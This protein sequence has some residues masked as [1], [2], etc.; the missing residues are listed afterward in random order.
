MTVSPERPGAVE[1]VRSRLADPRVRWWLVFWTAVGFVE[2]ALVALYLRFGHTRLESIRYHVYPFV[3]I[4]VALFAVLRSRPVRAGR[5]ARL[6]AAG[7]AFAYL[8]LLLWLPGNLSYDPAGALGTGFEW[9]M[10]VPGWGPVFAFEGAALRLRLVP[11]EAI[12]YA[13]LSYLVYLNLLLVSRASL[14]AVAAVGTCVGCT[15][16]VLVPL[17]G[18]LGGAGSSLASTAYA[19]SYDVGTALFVVVAAVLLWSQL[20]GRPTPGVADGQG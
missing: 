7:I 20:A 2:F 1:A 18:L 17:L 12:G 14:A 10:A 5:R 3:W 15:V 16:P 13:G 11:F 4:N 6:V 19:W 9:R 8:G